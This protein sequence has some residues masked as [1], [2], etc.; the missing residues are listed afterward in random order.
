MQLY[1]VDAKLLD[2]RRP[3]VAKPTNAHKE[4]RLIP[5]AP[6]VRATPLT[7]HAACLGHLP[8]G[9]FRLLSALL[10]RWSALYEPSRSELTL[11]RGAPLV[12]LPLHPQSFASYDRE[13]AG[14]RNIRTAPADLE[15]TTH[16]VAWGADLYYVMLRPARGF[17]MLGEDFSFALLIVALA[18]L[19][20]GAL[21]MSR[22]VASARLRGQWQ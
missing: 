17:D 9:E 7:C 5:Y 22:L 21:V 8:F 11:T 6:N 10:H 12:Q 2:A 1:D 3:K 15:S 19:A 16:V 20:G 18:A 13:V 4:E 14:V